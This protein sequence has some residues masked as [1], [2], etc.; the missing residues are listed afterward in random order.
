MAIPFHGWL[1]PLLLAAVPQ[2]MHGPAIDAQIAALQARIAS[3]Q[4]SAAGGMF[5][6]LRNDPQRSIALHNL[7][8]EQYFGRISVGTPPVQQTVVFDT[9][10]EA[11][12]IK[13][14]RC[15]LTGRRQRVLGG[16]GRCQGPN[17][18]GY[19]ASRSSTARR[20]ALPFIS[21]YGSSDAEDAGSSGSETSG[22]RV[23]DT[24]TMGGYDVRLLMSVAERE[25]ARFSGY[26]FDGIFG[27][28]FEVPNGDATDHFNQLCQANPSMRCVFSFYLTA[29]QNKPGSMLTLGGVL[30]DKIKPGSRWRTAHAI[31]FN[32]YSQQWGYWAVTFKHF[33]VGIGKFRD[34]A[35]SAVA[36]VDSGT[37][38][39]RVPKAVFRA[40]VA[41][42]TAHANCHAGG[43][44]HDPQY[45]CVGAH[46]TDFPP[47]HFDILGAGP[48]T[49]TGAEYVDCYSDSGKCFPRV[50]INTAET[51]E[52]FYILGD[53]FMRK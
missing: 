46:D 50:R 3:I 48:F 9:G 29:G 19:D 4:G 40:A 51:S 22:Q 27:L 6:D 15:T 16:T 23:S 36:I 24:V 28:D 39:I 26:K 47:L 21:Q 13:G 43:D 35:T 8:G 53:Y 2:S 49:L 10:S 31:A 41:A 17:D 32:G 45:E 5:P 1:L 18:G 38:Y 14:S 30:G 20:S 42:I 34:P 33:Q 11:L 7:W 37:T 44:R 25:S 52:P 12:V